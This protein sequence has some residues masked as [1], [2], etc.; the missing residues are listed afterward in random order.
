MRAALR[1]ATSSKEAPGALICYGGSQ[2]SSDQPRSDQGSRP[3]SSSIPPPF[4]LD[5]SLTAGTASEEP[6]ESGD[7]PG[8]NYSAVILPAGAG[9]RKRAR[10]SIAAQREA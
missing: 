10:T 5:P 2:S 9:A 1:R 6:R 4:S 3:Q 7:G 8:S